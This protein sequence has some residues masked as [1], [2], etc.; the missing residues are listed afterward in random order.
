MPRAV[1]LLR[2]FFCLVLIAAM[3]VA[4]APR[5]QRRT[6]G[7]YV[8]D[9]AI[10]ARIKT[11]LARDSETKALQI[12]VESFRGVVQLNGFVENQASI[13]RAEE[14]ARNIEGV[15]EVQN[16]LAVRQERIR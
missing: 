16:N 3:T 2:I 11:E 1:Q 6:A 9:K 7:T 10:A 15:Q 8:D 5:E 14:I 13:K 4:C 12:N